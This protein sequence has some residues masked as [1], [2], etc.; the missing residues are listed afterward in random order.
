MRRAAGDEEVDRD[1]GSTAVVDFGVVDEWSATDRAGSDG[2]HKLRG[3]NGG[4]SI[5]Q[6]RA[7]VFGN[8]TGD[9]DAVRVPR[10][11][12]NLDAETPEVEDDRARHV[13]VGFACVATAGTYLTAFQ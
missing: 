7:H 2:D 12:N 9:N 5:K 1:K 8:R 6:C 10:R 13:Q 11:C 3:G 4:I